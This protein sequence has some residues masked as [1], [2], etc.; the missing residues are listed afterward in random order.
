MFAR[1]LSRRKTMKRLLGSISMTLLGSVF[2][3]AACS[4][5]A[6]PGSPGSGGSSA[7]TTAQ[8]GGGGSTAGTGAAGSTAGTG[9]AGSAAAGSTAGTGAAGSAAGT[10]AAG[11]SAGTSGSDAGMDVAGTDLKVD[12]SIG[13]TASG[14]TA[15]GDVKAVATLVPTT[16]NTLAGTATFTDHAGIVTMVLTVTACPAGKHAFHLHENAV[17]GADGAAAGLHWVPKGEMLGEL[18]CAADGTGTVMFVTPSV[19]YWTIGGA[20]ATNMLLHALV[21]H[22]GDNTNP[23]GRLSCGVP[24]KL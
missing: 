1:K 21:V 16:G 3:V 17:C 11:S 10:G 24:A 8:T 12:T 9:A 15:A 5:S 13:D 18:T 20:V 22:T 4:D 14:D 7:G 2:L 6:K 23:G 19:G